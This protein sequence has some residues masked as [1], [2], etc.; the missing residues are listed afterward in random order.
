MRHRTRSEEN[1]MSAACTTG[2]PL[3]DLADADAFGRW[4]E[5][6]WHRAVAYARWIVRDDAA[7][8]DIAADALLSCWERWRVSAVPSHP[9]AYVTRAIHNLAASRA[10]RSQRDRAYLE[11]L[12]P[13]PDP[14]PQTAAEDRHLVDELLSLL[15]SHERTSVVLYYLEDRPGREVAAH[16]S[17]A[18]ATVRSHLLRARR[19][20]AA[21]ADS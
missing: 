17:V 6:H 20:L 9:W 14:S 18:P 8:E 12:G 7:A 1:A 3:I 11:R 16:L 4:Y 5:Q 2:S 15:P 21:T 13:C 10:R 19:R